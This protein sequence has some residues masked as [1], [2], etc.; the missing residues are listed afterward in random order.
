MCAHSWECE[1][2]EVKKE[3]KEESSGGFMDIEVKR[4][5]LDESLSSN[6]FINK[7]IYYTK[8]LLKMRYL[9]P[10]TPLGGMDI[11]TVIE[12]LVFDAICKV[13]DEETR[14]WNPETDP[15][16]AKYLRSVISSDLSHIFESAD[17]TQLTRL[18]TFID[19]A[20]GND[21]LSSEDDIFL[22]ETKVLPKG[23][24]APWRPP[25]PLDELCANDFLITIKNALGD[26]KE[27][28]QVLDLVLQGYKKGEIAKTMGV[29]VSLV[30]SINKRVKRKL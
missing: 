27:A 24:P 2:Q 5:M 6:S 7:L 9:S 12:D 16:L 23:F 13:Y 30:N 11:E 14:N 22:V 28:L 26:D 25:S 29:D 10:S 4:R 19:D 1:A 3:I 18:G 21:D 20:P 8:G 15:D 17:Y